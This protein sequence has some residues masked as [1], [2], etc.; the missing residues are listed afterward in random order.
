[1]SA[2]PPRDA[3]ASV[4]QRLLNLA[5]QRGEDFNFLL[6]R[7]A[8]ERLLYRLAQSAYDSQFVLKGAMLFHLRS[9]T[10]PHRPT[11]D[12]DFL[13]RGSPTPA[14]LKQMF[15]ELCT[16]QV[17]D[18]GLV[19]N[20]HSVRAE[21]IREEQDYEGVRLQLEARMGSARLPVQVDVGFGDALTP[22]P[23]REHLATLLDFPAPY[24]LIC[25]W[26]TVI[27]EKF[28]ALVDLGMA[29]SRM[30]DFFDLH[31]LATTLHLDGST[32]ATA[33]Q[34]TF[35]RRA[36]RGKASWSSAWTRSRPS[37]RWNAAS[38]RSPCS[39][40][41]SNGGS[42]S[43]S[44]MGQGTGWWGCASMMDGRGVGPSRGKA[45]CCLRTA[46]SAWLIGTDRPRS[47][48]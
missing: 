27:A 37:K 10:L 24:L 6:T 4:K 31:Y 34:A 33:I 39:R 21:P 48:M 18:D 44:G 22:P 46:W 16:A 41:A 8:V 5:T 29:N 38:P 23:K 13:G 36:W 20:K 32:L 17:V 42:M 11:R 30:R 45:R 9:G 3:A 7:Y 15:R 12:V 25:P 14:R 19:F 26:E 35:T 47:S 1:M 28:Q 2:R 43:T 40:V